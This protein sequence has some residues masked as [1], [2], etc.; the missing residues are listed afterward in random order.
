MDSI[1]YSAPA[2]SNSSSSSSSSSTSSSSASLTSTVTG[3]SSDQE[4]Q[5]SEGIEKFISTLDSRFRLTAEKI[6][7]GQLTPANAASRLSSLQSE[8]AKS[9]LP[10]CFGQMLDSCIQDC[11]IAGITDLDQVRLLA[12]KITEQ[13]LLNLTHHATQ[14]YLTNGQLDF[15]AAIGLKKDDLERL[16]N[17]KVRAQLATGRTSIFLETI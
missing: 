3:S 1:K 10:A 7:N 2:Y 5:R 16:S 4:S 8:L 11:I 14:L 13:S 9:V 6:S 15:E 12:N 17:P